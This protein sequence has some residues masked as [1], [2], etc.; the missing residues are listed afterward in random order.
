MIISRI[1]LTLALVAAAPVFGQDLPALKAPINDDVRA[2]QEAVRE[3]ADV[4][5]EQ[6]RTMRLDLDM[7]TQI[8]SNPFSKARV[9]RVGGASDALY[10]MGA[11][12]L[13]QHKYDQAISY[14]DRVI[15]AKT[16]RADGALYWKA[17]ALNRIGRSDEALASLAAL[18][19]DYPASHWLNDSEVLE[20]EVKQN[21]G[22]P[23][24]PAD[25]SNEEIKLM[26]INSLMRADPDRAVPLLEN[27]LKSGSSP[28]LKD[29]ALFVL[30][31]SRS[32]KAEQILSDYAKGAGNPD[33]QVRA[34]RYIGMSGTAESQQQL[35]S[36][37]GSTG[38][39]T[40]KMEIL[41]ALA[42]A[43]ARDQ[44]F[45][46]VKNEKDPALRGEAIR[47]LSSMKVSSD[48]LTSLYTPETDQKS[49][50]DIVNGLNSRGDAKA[51]VD[52]ARRESD[53]VMKKY[54]VE[55][56]STMHNNKEAT[57]YMIELLK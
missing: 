10:D 9:A 6:A 17:Y 46:L 27:L 7:Q 45:N 19:R 56:L 54:I 30:T 21:A 24:S 55:R 22:H 32:A 48:S 39:A 36:I 33:L 16:D 20:A 14:F 52:L 44:M 43:G 13:D 26:A 28:R 25:E 38:D 37:Y 50:R 8:G 11:S 53:P 1:S 23:I 51:L 29:R 12:L 15:A 57:D 40:V 42:S 49:K 4:L 5:R 34:I 47:Q 18:R 35:V 41:R 2:Q 31:Q 3:Q